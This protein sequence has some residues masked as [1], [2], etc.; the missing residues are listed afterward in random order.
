MQLYKVVFPI[1][2]LIDMIQNAKFFACLKLFYFLCEFHLLKDIVATTVN[3]YLVMV[4]CAPL[5]VL[6]F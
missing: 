1:W 6:L 2:N 3:A 5:T 4:L